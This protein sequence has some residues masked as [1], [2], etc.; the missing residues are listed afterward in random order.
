[1]SRISF[2]ARSGRTLTLSKEFVRTGLFSF[3]KNPIY[4]VEGVQ[5]RLFDRASALKLVAD[6]HGDSAE[7]SRILDRADGKEA[8]TP[9]AGRVQAAPSTTVSRGLPTRPLQPLFA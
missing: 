9:S 7:A 3:G 6:L 1:M 4:V 2:T 5:Q 8:F